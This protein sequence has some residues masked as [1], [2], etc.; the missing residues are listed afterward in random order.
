LNQLIDYANEAEKACL[1]SCILDNEAF[2]LTA[3]TLIQTDF[4]KSEL[5]CLNTDKKIIGRINS[6]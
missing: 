4:Y 5:I 1:G 6:Y 2:L 3:E